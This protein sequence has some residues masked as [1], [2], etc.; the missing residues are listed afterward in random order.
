MAPLEEKPPNSAGFPSPHSRIIVHMQLLT[1]FQEE[2]D[3]S[4]AFFFNNSVEKQ[5]ITNYIFF[6]SWKLLV[7]HYWSLFHFMAISSYCH[8]C[9]LTPFLLCFSRRFKGSCTWPTWNRWRGWSE[10]EAGQ[11]GL[12]LSPD[13]LSWFRFFL[14][15]TSSWQSV[16]TLNPPFGFPRAI[17]VVL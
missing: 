8:F 13:F 16:L 9:P 12:P 4:R 14:C 10:H 11:T 3:L 17:C 5:P 2:I 7:T 1:A 15:L 6:V